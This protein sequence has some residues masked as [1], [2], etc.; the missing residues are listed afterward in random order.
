MPET[1][2]AFTGKAAHHA[3]FNKMICKQVY[4]DSKARGR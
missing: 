3:T 2:Q 1:L 4:F